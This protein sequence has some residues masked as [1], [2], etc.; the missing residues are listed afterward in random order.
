MGYIGIGFYSKYYFYIFVVFLCQTICDLFTGFNKDID[1]PNN[2]QKNK[3]GILGNN[4]IIK[5]HY[6]L[7]DF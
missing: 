1:I 2:I 5:K 6:I 7:Q 4:F 3:D